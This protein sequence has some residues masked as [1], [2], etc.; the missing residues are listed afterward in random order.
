MQSDAVASGNIYITSK[1]WYVKLVMEI[2]LNWNNHFRSTG[3]TEIAVDGATIWARWYGKYLIFFKG[4]FKHTSQGGGFHQI[5]D[6]NG[7]PAWCF[8]KK[9]QLLLKVWPPFLV[10]ITGAYV[11]LVNMCASLFIRWSLSKVTEH[12][13]TPM[14]LRDF[15]CQGFNSG[16]NTR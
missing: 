3:S 9:W 11:G 2:T 4:F 15:I 5:C 8:A 14:R 7:Y 16:R 12:T 13:L 6:P 1:S 10:S